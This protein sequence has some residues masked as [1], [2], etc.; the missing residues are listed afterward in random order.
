M[1]KLRKSGNKQH[2]RNKAK[3]KPYAVPGEW[4]DIFQAIGHPSFILGPDHRI[5]VCNKAVAALTGKSTEYFIG[6]K[7]HEVFHVK[8]KPPNAC[9][10]VKLLKSGHFETVEMEMEAVG[11]TFLVSCTPVFGKSGVI[12]R[13]IHIATD[14][15]ERKQAEEK[16]RKE[17]NRAQTYLDIAA[18]IFVAID[19]TGMVTLINRKGCEILGRDESQI[20]G[21]NWF[22]S[23]VP[24]GLRD[25]VKTV[26]RQLMTGRIEPVE[27]FENPVLRRDGQERI[28]AWHNTLLRDEIGTITGTLSSGEDITER[29][30]A[31]Q[32]LRDNQKRLKALAAELSYAE[33]HERRRIAIGIHDNLSQKLAMAKLN[34]QFIKDSASE[35]SVQSAIDNACDIINKVIGDTRSLTFEL[36]NPIL[37]ELGLEQA[38]RTLLEN[39]I[40]GKGGPNCK[41]ISAGDKIDL[42]EDTKVVLFK[43]IRELLINIVK[44]AGAKNIK[45]GISRQNNEVKVAVEDDGA[46]FDVS[47]LGLPSGKEGGFGLFNIR[48]RLEYIGGRL[49]IESRLGKG[50]SVVMTVPAIKSKRGEKVTV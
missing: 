24:E 17:R 42:D 15:T 25:K 39:E 47:K 13:I 22:D 26:F 12:D 33:E 2:K 23:F 3:A 5:T 45:V 16:L 14:I 4:E 8:K 37:Y 32:N 18:V 40:K 50:T 7:C 48:E 27:Y 30:R 43:A 36:S 29:K 34:L 35:Q 44:H 21:K 11:R 31:E 46:G 49:E 9:P 10:M 20:I 28:I 1:A 38:V 41:F 6:R 19:A